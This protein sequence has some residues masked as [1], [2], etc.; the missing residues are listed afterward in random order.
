VGEGKPDNNVK[1]I[2][3]SVMTELS[4]EVEKAARLILSF[5]HKSSPKSAH[6]LEGFDR[7]F[8]LLAGSLKGGFKGIP[9]PKSPVEAKREISFS[10]GEPQSG[11]GAGSSALLKGRIS[12]KS[13]PH[14]W[15][16]YS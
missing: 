2:Q 5:L 12:S 3:G 6:Y 7:F 11:Q 10:P 15:Q 4:E 1:F 9:R 14:F 8:L 16:R 13:F